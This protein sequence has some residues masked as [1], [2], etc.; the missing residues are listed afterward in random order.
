MRCSK[1]ANINVKKTYRY[2]F[3]TYCKDN[4]MISLH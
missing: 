2:E 1:T 4:L 3:K